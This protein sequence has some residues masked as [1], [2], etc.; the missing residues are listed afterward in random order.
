MFLFVRKEMCGEIPRK[1]TWSLLCI[2]MLLCVCIYLNQLTCLFCLENDYKR[3]K[4]CI[5]RGFLITDLCD[6]CS[7]SFMMIMGR[8]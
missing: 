6:L 1:K 2:A 8:E 7:L 5:F 3:E 4:I